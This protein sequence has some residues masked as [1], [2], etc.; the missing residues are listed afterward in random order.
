MVCAALWL[1]WEH[2]KIPDKCPEIP[3]SPLFSRQTV[4]REGCG[5]AWQTCLALAAPACTKYAEGAFW[6]R[7]ASLKYSSCFQY[8]K[9]KNAML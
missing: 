8:Q 3:E 6:C 7:F 4:G 1:D 2:V 9:E 5:L